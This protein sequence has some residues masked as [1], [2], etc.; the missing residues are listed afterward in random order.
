MLQSEDKSQ[1][2]LR[3]C[4]KE[5]TGLVTWTSTFYLSSL[6]TLLSV[7]KK[8]SLYHLPIDAY[9]TLLPFDGYSFNWFLNY[10]HQVTMSVSS[11]VF[12]FTYF[13]IILILMNQ[14]CLYVDVTILSA[15]KLDF[16]IETEK[17]PIRQLWPNTKPNTKSDT[18]KQLQVVV[19]ATRSIQIWQEE[20]QSFLKVYFLIV[21]SYASVTMCMCTYA[22]ST[23]NLSPMIITVMNIILIQLFALCWMGS[24]YNSRVQRLE[25]A[26][27]DIKWYMMDVKQQKHVQLILLMTQRIKGFHGIFKFVALDT[28]QEVS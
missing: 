11:C 5:F 15:E 27:Y 8:D 22:L 19:E 20:L 17:K 2:V 1:L 10:L 7:F 4:R 18:A 13:P 6:L 28:F 24:R 14:T 12:I 25:M 3:F 23:N 26:I 9:F 21:F 16:I